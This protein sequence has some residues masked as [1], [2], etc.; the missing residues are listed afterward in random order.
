MSVLR[1]SRT[2]PR[3]L[4]VEI[5]HGPDRPAGKAAIEASIASILLPH[6]LMVLGLDI[7]RLRDTLQRNLLG[8]NFVS[9]DHYS[10][11]GRR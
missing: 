3:S 7:W 5:H 1:V 10:N 2:P 6:L 4:Q 11:G 9:A 8:C